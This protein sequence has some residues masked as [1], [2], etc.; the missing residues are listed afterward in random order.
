VSHGQ[1]HLP[2]NVPPA[3]G[4]PRLCIASSKGEVVVAVYKIW[5]R[6]LASRGQCT[7]P[8]VCG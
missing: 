5:L 6:D 1:P 2:D 3:R 7:I 8:G 4:A